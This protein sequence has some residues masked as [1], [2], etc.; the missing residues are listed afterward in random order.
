MIS[1]LIQGTLGWNKT[2]LDMIGAWRSKRRRSVLLYRSTS[3][4]GSA[5]SNKS[6]RAISS[7]N[8]VR[9]KVL[10]FRKLM[11]FT[12]GDGLGTERLHNRAMIRNIPI[13]DRS[14]FNNIIKI[15]SN[16]PVQ[17]MSL[18]MC[19]WSNMLSKTYRFQ[20]VSKFSSIHITTDIQMEIEIARS[21]KW[22]FG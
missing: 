8:S 7:L 1:L 21:A 22:N 4:S 5:S 9:S 18:S 2:F 13:G 16:Y 12:V 11:C 20:Q 3:F 10:S 17:N 15:T 14:T 6:I 19:G